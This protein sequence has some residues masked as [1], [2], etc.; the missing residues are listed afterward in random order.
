[1]V[2]TRGLGVFFA[3][4]CVASV[5]ASGCEGAGTCD[6]PAVHTGP[7]WCAGT[8]VLGTGSTCT[9]QTSDLCEGWCLP[10]GASD[11][12]PCDGGAGAG[13]AGSMDAESTDSGPPDTGRA[14]ARKD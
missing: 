12:V 8:E 14:D 3:A 5:V 1:M 2:A 13:D 4:L 10:S 11:P 7:G 6:C 9:C